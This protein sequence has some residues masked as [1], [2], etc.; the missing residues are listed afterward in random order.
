M[1]QSGSQPSCC[2]DDQL[3]A[4]LQRV[5]AQFEADSI[6]A[7]VPT[8]SLQ[9][10]RSSL[11][12]QLRESG[13]DIPRDSR[14]TIRYKDHDDWLVLSPLALQDIRRKPTVEVAITQGQLSLVS[15]RPMRV[16]STASSTV[17]AVP[18]AFALQEKVDG[19]AIWA[20][21]DSSAAALSLGENGEESVVIL[22][23]AFAQANANM[24]VSSKN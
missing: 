6:V 3:K 22:A 20:Q 16:S 15:P 18:A 13:F 21:A 10:F 5:R 7:E 9:D 4:P 8:T 14:L 19:G 11:L 2:A 17:E 23:Q 1:G 12:Q 24:H